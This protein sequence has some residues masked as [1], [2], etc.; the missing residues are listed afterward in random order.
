M[1]KRGLIGAGG[2]GGV[3]FSH[4]ADR[5]GY[6]SISVKMP[7]TAS[8][9]DLVVYYNNVVN[10]IS[11]NLPTYGIPQG[12]TEILD[13]SFVRSDLVTSTRTVISYKIISADDVGAEVSGMTDSSPRHILSVFRPD[14]PI[15]TVS[16]SIPSVVNDSPNLGLSKDIELIMDDISAGIGFF[17]CSASNILNSITSSPDTAEAYIIPTFSYG[18]VAHITFTNTAPDQTFTVN[19][20]ES[21]NAASFNVMTTFYITA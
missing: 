10:N 3:L 19:K 4:I 15:S 1:M 13:S 17:G 9:G 18:G 14:T 11:A 6:N 12:F 16:V 8:P 5:G 20:N 7:E 2:T 21:S